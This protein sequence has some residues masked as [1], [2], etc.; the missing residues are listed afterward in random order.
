MNVSEEVKKRTEDI[1]T[2]GVMNCMRKPRVD[3]ERE[4]TVEAVIAFAVYNL[5]LEVASQAIYAGA[6][7]AFKAISE[8]PEPDK[9]EGGLFWV[10][11]QMAKDGDADGIRAMVNALRKSPVQDAIAGVVSELEQAIATAE[12]NSARPGA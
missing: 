12:R 11:R 8:Q 6:D 2:E 7:S 3:R 10:A 1:I 9:W 5:G 4:N